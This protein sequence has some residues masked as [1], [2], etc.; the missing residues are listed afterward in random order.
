MEYYLPET[1]HL[2]S[3]INKQGVSQE[4]VSGGDDWINAMDFAMGGSHCLYSHMLEANIAREQARGVLPVSQYSEFFTTV[5]MRNLFHFLSLRRTPHAQYEIRQY[6][7]AIETLLRNIPDIS[8]SFNAFLKME[9]LNAAFHSCIE[10]SK[11]NTEQLVK[12]LS[13]FEHKK[14]A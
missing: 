9:E 3:A 2:Q 12:Y 13:E 10:K 14:E 5:N 11:K 4:T 6:A 8:S 1:L 7:H